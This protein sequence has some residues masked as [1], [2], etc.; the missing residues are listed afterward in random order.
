MRQLQPNV[1]AAPAFLFQP[2]I[3]LRVRW[4][5]NTDTPLPPDE[6]AGENPPDGAIIDYHLG[7]SVSGP[8]TLEI[9]DERKQVVRRYSSADPLPASDPML[10]IPPYWLRPPQTL[11][12]EPG[13]HRFLWDLQYAPVPGLSLSYPIAATYRNTAPNPTSPWVMPGKYTAVLTVNGAK[14]TQPLTLKMDPRVKA[15]TAALAEQFKL[16]K[17]LYDQWLMLAPITISARLIMGQLADLRA[18]AQSADLK[19]HIDAVTEKLTNVAGADARGPAAAAAPGAKLTAAT[20]SARLRTLFEI[21]QDVDV[22]PTPQA[23]AAVT[24]LLTESRPLVESWRTIL[25]TDIPSLNHELQAAGLPDVNPETK[26]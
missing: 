25:A 12:S 3:A 5:M 11:S 8:V 4:N 14:Y 13:M 1:T 10:A 15:T 18:R 7:P 16:A 17:D 23:A 6:P 24:D 21:I 22:A 20:A 26:K 9:L 2:Q 19:S